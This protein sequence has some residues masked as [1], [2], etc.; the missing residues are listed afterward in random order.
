M[1]VRFPYPYTVEAARWWIEYCNKSQP[2]T[3][4]AIV[5]EGELAGGCGYDVLEFERC[6]GAE[7]GYWLNPAYW[8]RGIATAAFKT[9]TDLAFSSTN[10]HRVQATIYSPN[11]ASARVAEKSGYRL[12]ARLRDALSKNGEIYD[13]LIYARL[14]RD[15]S[16]R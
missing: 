12:E 5:V 9:L 6:A 16:P 4:L 3:H 13:A 14:R 10:L 1:T 15:L 11:F 7:A 8:G 2:P